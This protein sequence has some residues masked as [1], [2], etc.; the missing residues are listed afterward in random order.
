MKI[1][2]WNCNGAFRKK[3][4]EIIKL[5]A[6]IYV[7]QECEPIDS[8]KKELKK[9]ISN[10]IW[11]KG[12]NT[13][14]VLVFAK[15]EVKLEKLEWD[16][17]GM[18]VF[19]PIMINNTFPLVAVWTTKPA[20]IEEFYIWQS[21][22]SKRITDECVIIGDFNSNAVWD[23]G[24]SE[25]GH[26]VVVNM[27]KDKGLESAYHIISGDKQGEETKATFYLHK[28]VEK[29]FHIDHCFIKKERI[30]SYRVL[31]MSW[32]EISDHIPV[33]LEMKDEGGIR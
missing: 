19:I 5:D 15:P 18:R 14:G 8:F 4:E 29:P 11:E 7:I 23:K 31:D 32:L 21:V 24:H 20:Y 13:K 3:Y 12:A 16:S 25:R 30:Q 27:L 6:D 17:Y 33:V 10:G 26:S 9:K 2:S 28:K 1:V 22:N